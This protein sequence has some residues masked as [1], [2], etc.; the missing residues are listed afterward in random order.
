MATSNEIFVVY[1]NG[2]KTLST[3]RV[4]ADNVRPIADRRDVIL[5]KFRRPNPQGGWFEDNFFGWPCFALKR[6]VAKAGSQD[7]CTVT[8]CRPRSGPDV[9]EGRD[10]N[11]DDGAT[12]GMQKIWPKGINQ[13]AMGGSGPRLLSYDNDAVD[14]QTLLNQALALNPDDTPILP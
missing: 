8:R 11:Y 4:L 3:A 2:D 14:F 6:Y 9:E 12:P 10:V 13:A 7:G 1:V 5:I